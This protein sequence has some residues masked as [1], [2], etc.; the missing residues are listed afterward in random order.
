MQRINVYC[1]PDCPN[2]KHL[3][4]LLSRD[5]IEFETR[6]FDPDDVNDIAE[7]AMMG[8]YDAQFPVVEVDSKRLPAMTV[9]DYMTVIRGC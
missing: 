7:M 6:T 3:K 8:I 9:A 2:C 4:M 5:G 1:I